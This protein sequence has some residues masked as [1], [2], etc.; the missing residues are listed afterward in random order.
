M[1]KFSHSV[2][3]LPFAFVAAFLAG[4][5]LDSGR[6][7][8]GQLGLM[9]LCMVAARSV[10]MT[11]NRIADAHS[12]SLNPRTSNRAI[13]AGLITTRQAWHFFVTCCLI[14]VLGCA[15][16]WAFYD[17]HWPL[18]LALPVLG[19]L[20]GYSYSKRF[21]RWSHFY[22]G[23]AIALS[24]AAT[25]VAIHPQSIGLP[26]CI[27]VGTVTFWIGGFDIIYACQDLD[28]DRQQGLFS[29]PAS[30]GP[31]VALWIARLAHL[32]TIVLLALLGLSTG[33]GYLYW[34]GVAI[35]A[36]LLV[37]EN[38]IVHPNDFSK[39]TL[40]FFTINGV[41]SVILG[42]VAVADVL[43]DLDPLIGNGGAS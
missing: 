39:I 20:C 14:F 24:P 12:D 27:L 4:R 3:A 43:L 6:P 11:F 29:L 1:I 19:Y 17:N 33:L 30:M 36:I 7:A 10:A 21:T 31:T 26:A 9:F 16:F 40:A 8:W 15:G 34:S 22:L 42:I 23:S 25:W 13:P 18:L 32:F 37:V 5:H 38:A 35:V 41:V 2:F 28:F